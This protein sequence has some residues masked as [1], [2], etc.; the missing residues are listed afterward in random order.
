M[1]LTSS[2]FRNNEPVPARHSYHGGNISPPLTI[3]GVPAGAVSLAL[4]CDDPDAPR[5][6]WVHWVVWNI[7]PKTAQIAEGGLPAGAVVGANSWGK[8][9]WG[10]PAPPSGT[11]H[12][13]FKLYAL[14][15]PVVL[16]PGADAKALTA[17]MKDKVLA[18]AELVGLYSAEPPRR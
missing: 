13:V 16:K 5:Q 7:D 1:E 14:K 18:K 2:A 17:A 8:A 3:A 4:I 6:T 15:A 12:Y 11:H 10:G 9:K